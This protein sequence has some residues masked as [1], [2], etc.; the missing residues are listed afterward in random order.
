MKKIMSIAATTLLLLNTNIVSVVSATTSTTF[1]KAL[2]DGV[3][4]NE[5]IID[6]SKFN[7]NANDALNQAITIFDAYPEAWAVNEKVSI[8]TQG[9]KAKAVIIKYDYTKDKQLLIQRE[10]DDVVKKAVAIANTF[11]TDYDKAKAVY[12]FLIDSYDYDWSLTKTKEYELFET[13]EGV[14]TAYSLAYKDIMQELGIPCLTVSSSEIAHMWNVVQI[15]GEWYNVD[16][17]WGDIYTA[18][19]ESFRY[20]NFMKSD[21][22]FQLLG[23]TGGV[24]EIAVKCTNSRYDNK[25]SSHYILGGTEA[26]S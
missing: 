15:D 10:I 20:E 13:G 6:I 23:H 14:C 12:D 8:Q 1:E 5:T 21:Y 3:A 25:K 24:A 9:S 11:Q 4:N 17:S 16:V 18:E 7:L 26:A 22:Y 19:S 2:L